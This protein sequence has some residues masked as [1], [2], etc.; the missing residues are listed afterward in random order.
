M[1]TQARLKELLHYNPDTGVFTNLSARSTSIKAGVSAGY[2]RQDGYVVIKVDSKPYKAHRLAWLYVHGSWPIDLIDHIR[3]DNKIS[4]LREATN[5]QNIQN[6]KA[7]RSDNGSGYLGVS[8]RKGC[9]KWRAT[10]FIDGM[11]RSLGD[12]DT[13]EL[14]SEAYLTAKRIHHEYCTI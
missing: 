6:L 11:N 10:I 8:F 13:P 4:N 1:L 3:S 12:F 9:G 14:A 7:A 2:I 5:R